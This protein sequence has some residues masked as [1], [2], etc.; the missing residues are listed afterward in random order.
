MWKNLDQKI[1][2]VGKKRLPGLRFMPGLVL[3]SKSGLAI[4]QRPLTPPLKKLSKPDKTDVFGDD[5]LMPKRL[6]KS[7]YWKI[8]KLHFD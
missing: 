2:R 8:V 7:N 1:R 4:A 5:F 6:K 3:L